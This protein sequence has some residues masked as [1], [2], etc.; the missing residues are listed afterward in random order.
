[1]TDINAKLAVHAAK[2]NIPLTVDLMSLLNAVYTDGRLDGALAA[3]TFIAQKQEAEVQ[4]PT[5]S[6]RSQRLTADLE[7]GKRQHPE[8]D[9]DKEVFIKRTP[10]R[11][12]GFNVNA[13]KHAFIIEGPQGGRYKCPL[14]MVLAGQRTTR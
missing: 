8:V 13:P 9:F 2:A 12:I 5:E 6:P 11:I 3:A 7:V 14:S 10:Y 1:M 4:Q